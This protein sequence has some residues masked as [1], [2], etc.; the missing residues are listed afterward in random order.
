MVTDARFSAD[1][2][3]LL[4]RLERGDRLSHSLV[5]VG[6]GQVL[7]DK[8]STSARFEPDAPRLQLQTAP[9]VNQTLTLP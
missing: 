5:D 6:S 4:L 7:W 1:G 9:G 2:R 8:A 3:W